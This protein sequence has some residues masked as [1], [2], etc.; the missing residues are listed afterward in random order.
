MTQDSPVRV[1]Q[2]GVLSFVGTRV[3]THETRL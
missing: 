3:H 2:G 1:A